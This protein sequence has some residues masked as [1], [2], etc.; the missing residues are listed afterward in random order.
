MSRQ[1]ANLIKNKL[2]LRT[3]L[4]SII[5]VVLLIVIYRHFFVSSG[6]KSPNELKVVEVVQLKKETIQQT[7]RLL[8]TIRP[9]HLTV[10]IAKG[11]GTFDTFVATGEKIKKGQLIAK[12]DNPDVENNLELSL[13]TEK[14]A[15][16]QYERLDKFLKTGF[17]SAKDVEE[18][19]QVWIDAQKELSKTRM[20]LDTLRFY[21]PFNGII[22]AFKKREGTQINPGDP[23]VTIYDPDTLIVDFDVP[24]TNLPLIKK[25]Q[26][27]RVLN[28][29]YPLSHIQRMIDDETHMCP[30]DV[31][32]ACD[33]CLIGSSVDIDLVVQEKK[34]VIVIPKEALFLRNG[35]TFVYTV[36]KG[37][38]VLVPVETGLQHQSRIEITSG[39]KL[40]QLLVIKGQERL[41]PD[42]Q[43]QIYQPNKSSQ[44]K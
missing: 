27:V 22:G 10:L 16:I 7:T 8:G 36:D 43:V 31:A 17:I 4:I 30:A 3:K 12:I 33:N 37:V 6:A 42:L 15:K 44:P 9:L 2:K 20:E 5:F 26:T 25:G 24:C 11:T 39:L 29:N 18:K 28:K 34:G 1:F 35:K 19:K 13:A 21:A 14:I 23:V 40:D 32:I 38:I 41:Y